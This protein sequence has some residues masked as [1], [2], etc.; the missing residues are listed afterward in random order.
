MTTDQP[1]PAPSAEASTT[2]VDTL[3]RPWHFLFTVWNLRELR[4]RGHDWLAAPAARLKQAAADPWLIYDTVP[5]LLAGQLEER[6]LNL[7]DLFSACQGEAANRLQEAWLAAFLCFFRHLIPEQIDL[8]ETAES[9]Q[10]TLKTELTRL[11][12]E[13]LKADLANRQA[14]AM[15]ALKDPA[16]IG[17]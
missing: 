14:A 16:Q 10:R 17:T 11:A 3:G 6:G 9:E 12:K 13:R 8:I 5:T 1:A 4:D 2:F 7:Q 15:A